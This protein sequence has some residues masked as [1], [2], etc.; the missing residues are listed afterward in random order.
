MPPV[1]PDCTATPRPPACPPI[2]PPEPTVPVPFAALGSLETSYAVAAIKNAKL[3]IEEDPLYYEVGE[4]VLQITALKHLK[5]DVTV[6]VAGSDLFTGNMTKLARVE[7]TGNVDWRFEL[8]NPGALT[9]G[10]GHLKIRLTEA[11]G[12]S[13]TMVKIFGVENDD[14]TSKRPITFGF[15]EPYNKAM[16]N[17]QILT[18]E[19]DTDNNNIDDAILYTELWTN[20]PSGGNAG[21]THYMSGGIWLLVPD[22]ESEYEAYDFGAFVRSNYYTQT[23]SN[24]LIYKSAEGTAQ[25]KGSAAGLYVSSENNGLK[26]SRLLGKVTIDADFMTTAKRGSLEGKIHDLTLD[27]KQVLGELLLNRD[28]DNLPTSTY[29]IGNVNGVNFTGIIDYTTLDGTSKES[30]TKAL[31][32]TIGGRGENGDTVVGTWGAYKVE[33][34]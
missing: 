20:Y 19:V 14:W 9:A 12:S 8:W 5:S 15:S 30:S 4:E 16:K 26:I 11:L 13:G 23:N 6:Q 1:E 28:L 10:T 33:E 7:H 24:Y 18:A 31:M 2:T 25:Y 3:G 29:G 32:G 22:D 21:D 17:Y 34:E 27:G